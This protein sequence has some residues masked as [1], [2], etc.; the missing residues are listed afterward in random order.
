MVVA[1]AGTNP[2]SVFANAPWGAASPA[3][4]TSNTQKSARNRRL[5]PIFRRKWRFRTHQ[6][7][8]GSLCQPAKATLS[9]FLTR[10]LF[11]VIRAGVRKDD[12]DIAVTWD[13]TMG[14]SDGI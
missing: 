12:Q 6:W 2:A 5:R 10:Y 13:F 3:C 7:V 8:F 14:N 1:M 11:A 4:Q 9:E